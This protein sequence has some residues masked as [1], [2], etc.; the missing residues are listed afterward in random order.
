M[1]RHCGG[2]GDG[3]LLRRRG[4]QV[5]AGVQGAGAGTGPVG[6]VSSLRGQQD[7]GCHPGGASQSLR[8][9]PPDAGD[10]LGRSDR[11]GPEQTPEGVD[12]RCGGQGKRSEVQTGW[13]TDQGQDQG[14][15]PGIHIR[16]DLV[17]RRGGRPRWRR[18]STG[19]TRGRAM[20]RRLP[21]ASKRSRSVPAAPGSPCPGSWSSSGARGGFTKWIRVPATTWP[22]ACSIPT[23]RRPTRAHWMRWV[24]TRRPRWRWREPEP[25]SRVASSLPAQPA[26]ASRRRWCVACRPSTPNMTGRSPL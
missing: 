6:P 25:S 20:Q 11:P 4:A 9:G 5:A 12:G 22:C 3:C 14:R 15:G 24:S 26:T 7:P 8:H 23:R 21:A 17:G 2:F 18:S 1:A 10:R 16:V 13:R 19:A